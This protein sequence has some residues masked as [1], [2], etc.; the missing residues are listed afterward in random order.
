VV[1]DYNQ[2]NIYQLKPET[3][4]V[5]AIPMR[6]CNPVSLAF[7]LSVNALYV[8]C[9][10]N[11]QHFIHKKTFDGRIDKIIYNVPRSKLMLSLQ[12]LDIT[13]N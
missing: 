8:I 10:Q 3:G 13:T 5:R 6:Q 12:Y 9:L 1:A 7:D 2:Q 4:E 11:H